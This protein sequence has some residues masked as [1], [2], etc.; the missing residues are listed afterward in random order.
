MFYFVFDVDNGHLGW[1]AY[2]S[3]PWE[4]I[5]LFVTYEE[6]L[7]SLLG[8]KKDIL[9]MLKSI[10]FNYCIFKHSLLTMKTSSDLDQYHILS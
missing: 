8:Q 10:S 2:F 4:K 5:I 6:G 7:C 3:L 1:Q 9:C